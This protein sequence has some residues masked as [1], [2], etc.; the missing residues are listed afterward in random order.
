MLNIL[1]TCIFFLQNNYKEIIESGNWMTIVTAVTSPSSRG[2]VTL[3]S[4][5][6]LDHPLIDPNFLSTEFDKTVM[7]EAIR[8]AQTYLQ[9]PAFEGY[10]IEPWDQLGNRTSDEEL[11]EY[12]QSL[13]TTIFHP[14]GTAAMSSGDADYGVVNPDLLV[15]KTSGLRIVDASVFVSLKIRHTFKCINADIVLYSP[16][17]PRDILWPQHTH[18]RSELQT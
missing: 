11:D 13:T 6:P 7:R 16:S 14:T 18:W 17:Y 2:T 12:I 10:I 5:N 1:F 8:S 3:N 15:K 4:S 9:A